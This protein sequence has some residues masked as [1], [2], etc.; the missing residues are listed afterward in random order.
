M[1]TLNRYKAAAGAM[2]SSLAAL[3]LTHMSFELVLFVGLLSGGIAMAAYLDGY[4]QATTDS[5]EET[6]P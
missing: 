4:N 3:L 2:T 6:E 1:W 5:R